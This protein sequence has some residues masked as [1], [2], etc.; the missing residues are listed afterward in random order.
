MS[1][2]Q[3]DLRMARERKGWTMQ[4][5]ADEAGTTKG[6]ISRL[7]SGERRNP[8]HALVTR[9]EEALGLRPGTLVFGSQDCEVAR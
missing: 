8:S 3:L 2:K 4:R 5:L 7:E 6:T 1:V 9:L